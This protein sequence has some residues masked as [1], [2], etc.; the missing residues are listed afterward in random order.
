M[1]RLILA[2]S[3][4]LVALPALALHIVADVDA[5]VTSCGVFLDALPKS[6]V[7]AAVIAGQNSCSYDASSLAS[8]PHSIKMT[9]MYTDP[10][11]GAFESAQSAAFP[12]TKLAPP[13]VPTAIRL[14]P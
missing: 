8:G 14:A 5:I 10:I 11:Q 3:L 13:A 2:L 7:P 9:A 4:F 1:K 6:T 12:F